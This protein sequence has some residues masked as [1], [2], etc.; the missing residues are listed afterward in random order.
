[1]V[2]KNTALKAAI[3]KDGIFKMKDFLE[4]IQKELNSSFDNAKIVGFGA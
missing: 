1:M 4:C 2:V 3:S